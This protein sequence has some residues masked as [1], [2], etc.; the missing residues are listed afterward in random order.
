MTAAALAQPRSPQQRIVLQGLEGAR[1]TCSL[2]G[3][4]R[5]FSV[6]EWRSANLNAAEW[7]NCRKALQQAQ[8][9]AAKT[10]EGEWAEVWVQQ[11]PRL[12]SRL[13]VLAGKREGMP[14]VVIQTRQGWGKDWSGTPSLVMVQQRRFKALDQFIAKC[15]ALQ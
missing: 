10:P 9:K 7:A 5:E 8:L 11:K 3:E 13:E 1:L 4:E 14:V 12:G 2:N 6:S 15:D